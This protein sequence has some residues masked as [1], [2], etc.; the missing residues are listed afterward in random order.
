LNIDVT[1]VG[2]NQAILVWSHASFLSLHAAH[3]FRVYLIV[4]MSMPFVDVDATV[5]PGFEMDQIRAMTPEDAVK[6]LRGHLIHYPVNFLLWE[7]LKPDT[8]SAEGVIPE[9]MWQ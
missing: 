5:L 3:L 8:F 6:S 7:T 4:I 9:S 2:T 1:V